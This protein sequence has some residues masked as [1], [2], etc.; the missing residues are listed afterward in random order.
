M[1]STKAWTTVLLSLF[2]ATGCGT[3]NTTQ[4]EEAIASSGSSNHM[5]S[6]DIES[7]DGD[8]PTGS[9]RPV[10]S[11]GSAAEPQRLHPLPA[12]NEPTAMIQTKLKDSLIYRRPVERGAFGGRG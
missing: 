8:A 4:G 2:I 11:M 10:E 12:T 6:P 9:D 1:T 3:S 5:N 7:N